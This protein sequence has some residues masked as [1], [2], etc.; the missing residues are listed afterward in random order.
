MSEFKKNILSA[1][2]ISEFDFCSI[3]WFVRIGQQRFSPQKVYN[4][5][6]EIVKTGP[7][8]KPVDTSILVEG[9]RDFES[10]NKKMSKARTRNTGLIVWIILLIIL[11]A[12]LVF[13][14]WRF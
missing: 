6:K 4:I 12:L 14:G 10:L 5:I 11:T 8:V 2:E 1:T 7:D 13:T 9:E 3:S